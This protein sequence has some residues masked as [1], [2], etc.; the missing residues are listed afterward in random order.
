MIDDH[1]HGYGTMKYNNGRIY[2]GEWKND[3]RHGQG[4]EKYANGNHYR[5]GFV[6]GKA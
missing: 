2:T 5:G 1:R 3:I 4:I 6:D